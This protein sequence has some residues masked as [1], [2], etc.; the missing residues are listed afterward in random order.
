MSTTRFSFEG[1]TA[2]VMGGTAGIGR[3][4]AIAFATAGANVCVVGLG[5]SDGEEVEAEVRARG[6]GAMFM[7][8]DVI[9]ESAVKEAVTRAAERFGRI[10]AAVNNAGTEGRYGP[11]HELEEAEFDRIIGVN[12][13][14][15]WL[16]LKYQI[17]HM[18]GHGGGAI[19]NTASS[20]GV[21]GIANVAVYTAS[22][23]GVVGLTKASALELAQSNVRVNAIAPGPV[24]TGLLRRMVGGHLDLSVIADQVPMRRIS[25]PEESAQAILWLCSDAASY[26]TGH[27]LVVDGGLTV[28]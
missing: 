21:T 17:P 11:V 8:V 26:I 14:G 6:V 12:L 7:E 28:G 2:L 24:D 23:H 16:G 13:K 22:K 18:L 5:V 25:Q 27:T 10:H 4:T 19:V 3:A 15:I 1:K 20:A 9:R